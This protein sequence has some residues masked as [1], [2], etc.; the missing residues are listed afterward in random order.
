MP[1]ITVGITCYNA[2]D[3]IEDAIK[4]ALQQAWTNIEIVIVDDCSTDNSVKNINNILAQHQ[5][6]SFKLIIHKKNTGVAGARNTIIKNASGSFI[7]F[8]DDDDQSLSNRLTRQYYRII[9]YEKKYNKKNLL[10][11]TARKQI[12][13]DRQFQYVQTMATNEKLPAPTGLDIARKILFGYPKAGNGACATCSQMGRKITYEKLGLF[14]ETFRLSEDTELNVRLGLSNGQVIGIKDA[15]VIQKMTYTNDKNLEKTF[16]Y[17]QKLLDEYE[18][19]I[20]K[21]FSYLFCKKWQDIKCRFLA[22]KKLI[23][24]LKILILFLQYPIK[25]L[26]KISWALPNLKTNLHSIIFYKRIA[27]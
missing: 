18:E 16:F 22:G 19:F 1:L 26:R 27:K 21:Y 10:C 17:R 25:T 7:A 6:I 9:E 23:P 24:F 5:N 2:Q 3:T 20:D 4:S 11:H 14:D 15:L 12:Y 13:C 8:F